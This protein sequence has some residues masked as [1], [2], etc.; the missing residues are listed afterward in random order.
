MIRL[1]NPK[2]LPAANAAQQQRIGVVVYTRPSTGVLIA[3][4]R[5]LRKICT[6]AERGAGAGAAEREVEA[7]LRN[8]NRPLR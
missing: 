6:V 2:H 4:R 5:P 7:V 3:L 1:Q 8:A